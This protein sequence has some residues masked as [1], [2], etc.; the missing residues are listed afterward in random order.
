VHTHTH[1]FIAREGQAERVGELERPGARSA[2][3]RNAPLAERL[4]S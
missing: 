2:D 4:S 3:A 1:S